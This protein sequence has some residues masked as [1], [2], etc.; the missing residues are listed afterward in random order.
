MTM[1]LGNFN[2]GEWCYSQ[3]YSQV[4]YLAY[5]RHY[6]VRKH[7]G[8]K[9]AECNVEYER[10]GGDSVIIW[11]EECDLLGVGKGSL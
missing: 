4:P 9:H 5:I 3:T 6:Q 2:T 1:L 8:E 11:V 7:Q 10:F